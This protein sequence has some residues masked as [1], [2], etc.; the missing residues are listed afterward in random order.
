MEW[1]IAAVSAHVHNPYGL[2]LTFSC[3]GPAWFTTTVM[4]SAVSSYLLLLGVVISFVVA[5]VQQPFSVSTNAFKSYD[6]GLFSPMED[7]SLLSASE[8]TTLGHPLFP[9]YNVRIK[10]SDFCD[11]SVR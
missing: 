5:V 10:K 3:S 9:N 8:F 4:S 7:L 6:D 1:P 2:N 11:G